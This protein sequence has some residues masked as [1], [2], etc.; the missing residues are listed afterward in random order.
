MIA[1]DLSLSADGPKAVLVIG[2]GFIGARIGWAT[3]SN[4]GQLSVLTRSDGPEVRAVARSG[5]RVTIANAADPDIISGALCGV[6]HVIYAAGGL[7]PAGSNT[8][9]TA[10]AMLSLEPLLTVLEA[11]RSRPDIGL[12][13]L[14]SGGTVYGNP[15]RLPVQEDDP[16]EPMTAYG[17]SK[18]ACE[19]YITMYATLY[20]IRARVLRCSNVYGEGQRADRMQGAVAVFIDC[21]ANHRP[22]TIWGN[23]TIVR[24]YLYIDD[25]VAATLRLAAHHG[26]PTVVNVGSGDGHS[27]LQLIDVL[28]AV[29]GM[30]AKLQFAA[31]RDFDVREIVLDIARLRSLISY[32]PLGLVE[33]IATTWRAMRS[34]VGLHQNSG[35]TR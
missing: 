14:S 30:P 17:I 27:L 32:E 19:K 13:F 2:W 29:T 35:A 22:I 5:A 8:A 16:T 20:G 21:M 18:L 24:D 34:T 1:S 3:V 4:G 23:G 6:E 12:T 7:L 11:L 26:G 28:S 31:G 15:A 9:P 33:G 10:D 25:V